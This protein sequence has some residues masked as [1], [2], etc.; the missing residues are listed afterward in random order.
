MRG[1]LFERENLGALPTPPLILGPARK[2]LDHAIE[3]DD[4]TLSINGDDAVSY[5]AQ[6]HRESLALF[7]Q[8]L[9]ILETVKNL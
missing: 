9:Q 5:A 4:S 2:R 7:S 8:L 1:G 6:G 3:Q